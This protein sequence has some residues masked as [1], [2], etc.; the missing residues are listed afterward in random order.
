MSIVFA[1]LTHTRQMFMSW[2]AYMCSSY[3][4]GAV[5]RKSP[6]RA[7]VPKGL[8]W[9]PM[10]HLSESRDT[11]GCRVGQNGWRPVHRTALHS[12][13]W[14][15]PNVNNSEVNKEGFTFCISLLKT[16][17]EAIHLFV[18]LAIGTCWAFDNE[19]PVDWIN[20]QRVT[21]IKDR[22]LLK[23]SSDLV[24]LDTGVNLKIKRPFKVRKL[25]PFKIKKKGIAIW[26]ALI[27][28]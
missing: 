14:S 6:W 27:Q 15:D 11:F 7:A 13:E 18:S 17:S 2:W 9:S 21:V 16:T 3:L 20:A 24:C 10:G 4:K 12:K 1:A 26:D 8:T 19:W 28:A 22:V 25:Q 5:L 23:T